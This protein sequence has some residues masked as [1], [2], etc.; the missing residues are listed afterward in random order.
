MS[1]GQYSFGQC[2]RV[3][4]CCLVGTSLSTDHS[5]CSHVGPSVIPGSGCDTCIVF[6][7]LRGCMGYVSIGNFCLRRVYVPM[8]SVFHAGVRFPAKL[9]LD[10]R[11]VVV[12]PIGT[13]SLSA[14]THMARMS[15]TL[16]ERV[17]QMEQ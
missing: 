11:S 4:K 3:R 15:E 10:P 17:T 16:V 13:E 8:V 9:I 12:R 14:T 1:Y 2:C 7:D 5:V 6:C